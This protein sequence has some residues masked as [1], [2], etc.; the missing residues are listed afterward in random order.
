MKDAIGEDLEPGDYVVVC[1]GDWVNNMHL[2]RVIGG[3]S[4]MINV[5]LKIYDRPEETR[6][7]P[8]NCVSKVNRETAIH[9]SLSK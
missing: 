3:G 4:R 1:L 5:R 2:G 7:V 8:I 6:L 9:F